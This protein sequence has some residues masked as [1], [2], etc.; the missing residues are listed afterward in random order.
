MLA[1]SAEVLAKGV[2]RIQLTQGVGFAGAGSP[3]PPGDSLV[4]F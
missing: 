1:K 4:S 3:L 2:Q